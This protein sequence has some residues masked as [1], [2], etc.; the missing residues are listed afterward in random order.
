MKKAFTIIRV[1]KKDQLKGYGPDVQWFGDVLPN[2]PKLGLEVSEELRRVIQEEATGWDRD[3]FQE[4]VRE[5][6]CCYHEGKVTVLLFPRV[7][8]ETRFVFGSFPLLCEVIKEGMEVYFARD[9]FRLNPF[10]TD[11]VQ[12]YMRKAIEA[13]EYV[14]DWT[15]TSMEAKRRR[16][17][18]DHMMPTGRSKWAYDYHPYRKDSGHEPDALSGHYTINKERAAWVKQWAD[19]VLTGGISIIKISRIMRDRHGI[20]ISRSTIADILNDDIL[21]GKVYAYRTKTV[22]DSQ[23]RRRTVKT[24]KNE[25]LLVYEDEGLRII[26]DQQLYA[27]KEK[28]RQNR[29]N[30][31]RNTTHWYPPLRSIVFCACGRRMA[32]I[33]L[34]GVEGQTYYR[35]LKCHRYIKAVPLWE[36][37]KAGVKERLLQ[38]ELLIPAIKAQ[39]DSGESI[40]RLEEEL[41]SN[42]QRLDALDQAETKALRLHLYVPNYPVKKLNEETSRIAE[43]REP[44]KCERRSLEGRLDELRQAMVDEEGL[45][46]F[47]DIAA[48]NL[49]AL[50]DGQWRVL[51]ETI[52]LKVLAK[53]T[54]ITVKM[55]VPTV[56]EETTVIVAGTSPSYE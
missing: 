21:V 30:S 43:Q 51:L 8:R 28:F 4:A 16:A 40:A 24:P 20:P 54:G 34:G 2:A 17:E 35:C 9:S 38:P 7:D 37:I 6:L 15:K 32:G 29:Q 50:D 49:D 25:W 31:S 19:W 44:L 42:Q 23:G 46:R 47:C 56:K 26:T 5:G 3:R 10:D 55:S 48:R 53:D 45:R 27:L 36:D 1:S 11:S 33:T 18:N 52:K 22:M 14:E 13:Q 12:K 39:L 41:R